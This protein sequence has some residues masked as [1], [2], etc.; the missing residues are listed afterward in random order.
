MPEAAASRCR[1]P[2]REDGPAARVAGGVNFARQE[3]RFGE[4]NERTEGV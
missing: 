1:I 3:A 2:G 4:R